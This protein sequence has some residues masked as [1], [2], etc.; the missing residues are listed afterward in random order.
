MRASRASG[1][2]TWPAVLE[3]NIWNQNVAIE[4][5]A[6]ATSST[7]D[8]GIAFSFGGPNNPPSPA[9]AAACGASLSHGLIPGFAPA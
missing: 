5:P 6:F 1:G 8:I 7:K 9:A 4:D 3:V 2:T